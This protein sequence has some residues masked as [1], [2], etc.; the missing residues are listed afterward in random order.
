MAR[1]VRHNVAEM[2]M[3]FSI[4]RV[5]KLDDFRYQKI[6][7]FWEMPCSEVAT[8]EKMDFFR[9]QKIQFFRISKQMK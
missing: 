1:S 8:R 7:K 3:I 2:L 4:Q 6:V 5:A 9:F